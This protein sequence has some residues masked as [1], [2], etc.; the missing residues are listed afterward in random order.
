MNKFENHKLKKNFESIYK[1]L[2]KYIKFDDIEIQKQTFYQHKGPI[3]IT[4]IDINKIV[5]SN[6][7]SFGKK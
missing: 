6:N 5:V 1:N 3:S 7:V 4:N 2:K